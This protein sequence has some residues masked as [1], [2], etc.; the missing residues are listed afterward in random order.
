VTRNPETGDA[1]ARE[2]EA[3]AGGSA[4][5]RSKRRGLCGAVNDDEG[6]EI[7]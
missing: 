1:E 6:V 3:S 4:Y 2:R 7:K 5:E